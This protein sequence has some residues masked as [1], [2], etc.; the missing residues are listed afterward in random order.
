MV[1]QIYD[2]NKRMAY[3]GYDTNSSIKTPIKLN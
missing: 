3:Y 2:I 1:K